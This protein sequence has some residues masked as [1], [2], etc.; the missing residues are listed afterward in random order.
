MSE[1]NVNPTQSAECQ[2]RVA[3][4][5]ATRPVDGRR[6]QLRENRGGWRY[7]GLTGICERLS[8]DGKQLVINVEHDP[9]SYWP[10]GSLLLVDLDHETQPVFETDPPVTVTLSAELA[11]LLNRPGS[12][13][14]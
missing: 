8:E 14:A 9:E 4:L 2:A 13:R 6:V 12:P 3:E 1:P 5:L 7:T 11:A 10:A